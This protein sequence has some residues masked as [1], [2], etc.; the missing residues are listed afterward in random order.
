MLAGAG[1]WADAD[2]IFYVRRDELQQ[3]LYDYGNGWAVGAESIGPY[4]WPAEI[5]RRRSIIDA[6][7][8][9]APPPAMN[10]PPAVV[11][12]PFTIMLYGITTDSVSSWL[13]GSDASDEL[14]GMAASPGHGRGT[15]A[16]GGGRV[17]TSTR[18]RRARCS[19]RASP[20]RA[21]GRCSP[22]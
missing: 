12:E 15:G 16:R 20:R 1:F 17:A 6:L 8:T 13:S 9:K 14:S 21:G 2:D 5:A 11:T 4:H 18:S 22:A 3:V 19:W 10:E 7:G